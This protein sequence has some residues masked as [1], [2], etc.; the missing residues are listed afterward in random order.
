M[1]ALIEKLESDS[2]DAICEVIGA[3]REYNNGKG[4]MRDW[5][6]HRLKAAVETGRGWVVTNSRGDRF[7]SWG[8]TGPTWTD[9][10]EH[11]IRYARRQDAE[12][13]HCEDEDAW[14]ITE[15]EDKDTIVIDL[16]RSD[17]EAILRAASESRWI[18]PEY[19]RNDWLADVMIF[20]RDGGALPEKRVRHLKR[21]TTYG[22]LGEAEAQVATFAGGQPVSLG[23][24]RQRMLV[25][26]DKLTVYRCE[27]TGK[28]Y[29]RFPDEFEDGRFEELVA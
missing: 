4:A 5:F 10:V 20:L 11:A 12:A 3:P 2:L 16:D 7:R 17:W 9:K 25:E 28:L 8:D 6:L 26:G 21:G 15:V 22:V 14:R 27:Q 24:T 1:K 18:P 29:L 13:V 19:M 23:L